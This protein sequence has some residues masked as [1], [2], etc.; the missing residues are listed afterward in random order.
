MKLVFNFLA[1]AAAAALLT[2]SA[3]AEAGSSTKQVLADFFP[4]SEKVSFISFTPSATE[5]STI[6]KRLGYKLAKRRYHFYVAKTG[7]RVD[8]YA[9][10]DDE[11]GQHEPITYAV[12]L[13]AAGVVQRSEVLAYRERFGGEI[14]SQ[15]FRK[16][17]VG[18]SV[19]DSC[20]AGRDVHV[21]SGA[22]ISSHSMARGVRRALVLFDLAIGSKQPAS[23][24]A[25]LR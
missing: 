3:P 17:F 19:K 25:A 8:G 4:D 23:R 11:I 21:I 10:I 1:T 2:L 20:R 13:S 9:F 15:R 24:T 16:Q 18:M 7:D 5:R 14:K 12:K 22:T 6:A